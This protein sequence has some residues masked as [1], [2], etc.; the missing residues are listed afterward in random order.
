LYKN[1]LLTLLNDEIME[2]KNSIEKNG[3]AIGLIT[4]AA[5]L[6]YFFIMKS[7]GLAHVLELRFFN[8]LIAGIGIFYG[9]SKLK[10][11]LREDQFY[12]KG[13]AQGIYIAAVSVVTFSI[14]LSFYITYFDASLAQTIKTE[15]NI[16]T[17]F[18]TFTLFITMLMEGMAG[19]AI[20][21]FVSMQFLKRQGDEEEENDTNQR[22]KRKADRLKEELEIEQWRL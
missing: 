22:R 18:S 6:G 5:L 17:S 15:T 7:V 16:G 3:F 10:N 4:S 12:L 2:T 20:I 11:D 8:F 13:W 9:I 21:T 19:G 1:G 14:V